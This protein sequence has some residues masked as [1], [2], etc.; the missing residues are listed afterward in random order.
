[1][2]DN[3]PEL[4]GHTLNDDVDDNEDDD[5]DGH[6]EDGELAE[7]PDD[8]VEDDM[9]ERNLRREPRFCRRHV[10]PKDGW[11][12]LNLHEAKKC[13]RCRDRRDTI[14]HAKHKIHGQY[15]QTQCR[16]GFHPSVKRTQCLNGR[17]HPRWWR[18]VRN[19][20]HRRSWQWCPRD[21]QKGAPFCIHADTKS[22]ECNP[23]KC[24]WKRGRGCLMKHFSSSSSVGA[25]IIW[26]LLAL[27]LLG[28]GVFG[29][30]F[31][32]KINKRKNT[33]DAGT[34]DEE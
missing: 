20:H 19:H 4:D 32:L 27:L 8:D 3:E 6:L 21:H 12:H 17:F 25:I 29:G 16:K 34:S 2:A 11:G 30:L 9:D 1:M 10:V 7:G 5:E 14:C 23:E 13:R 31:V 28:S 22:H 33:G 24:C 18:C 26:V 15:C